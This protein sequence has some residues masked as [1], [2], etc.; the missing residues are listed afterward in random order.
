MWEMWDRLDPDPSDVAMS[1]DG[2]S[3]AGWKWQLNG[4]H[5]FQNETSKNM[6]EAVWET[7]KLARIL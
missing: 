6:T 1:A 2:F 3:S 4:G 7:S 5:S